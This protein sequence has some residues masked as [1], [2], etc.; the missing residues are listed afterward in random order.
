[1]GEPL[2]ATA[3]QVRRW[4]L[5]EQPGTWGGDA[6]SQ[7]ALPP[8]VAARLKA[9]AGRRGARLLLIRRFGRP[10]PGPLSCFV[11]ITTPQVQHIERL[12]V[13][14]ADQ[15]LDVDW[16]PLSHDR[17]VGGDTWEGPLFLV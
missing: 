5:V 10:N 1:M 14:A 17:P 11:A 7:S 2:Y 16:S 3:S 9:E 8:P 13:D 12:F 6:V 4:L 15:L